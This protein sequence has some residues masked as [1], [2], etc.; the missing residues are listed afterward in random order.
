MAS[1]IAC[2]RRTFLEGR[3]W[4]SP[5]TGS[6]FLYMAA[7]GIDIQAVAMQRPPVPALNFGRINSTRT[8]HETPRTGLPCWLWGGECWSCGSAGY[9]GR[10]PIWTGFW[11]QCRIVTKNISAGPSFVSQSPP[12]GRGL[13][14]PRLI[15][16]W[17]D[18]SKMLTKELTCVI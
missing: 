2:T 4:C 1:G 6:A 5:D 8:S 16:E 9:E 17:H 11:K 12:N 13:T 10:K 18:A 14:L 15:G 7:S 3:I